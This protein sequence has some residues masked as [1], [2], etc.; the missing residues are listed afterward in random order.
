MVM[1]VAEDGGGDDDFVT[2][3]SF[4]GVAAA[5]DLRGN[6]LDDDA[7]ATFYGFHLQA[8]RCGFVGVS[9]SAD[10]VRLSLASEV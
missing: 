10:S 3:D 2:D 7:L 1:A 8:R 9:M 5:I 6:L 4:C